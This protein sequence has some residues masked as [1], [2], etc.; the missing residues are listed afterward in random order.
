VNSPVV[1]V[2]VF[3]VMARIMNELR[4]K[5]FSAR[6]LKTLDMNQLFQCVFGKFGECEISFVPMTPQ[7]RAEASTDVSGMRTV[8]E[9]FWIIHRSDDCWVRQREIEETV[10]RL[11]QK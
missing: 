4:I 6:M 5:Y 11:G 1:S 7:E 9:R 2:L 3:K 10:V 8:N